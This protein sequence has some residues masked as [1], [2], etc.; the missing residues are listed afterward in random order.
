MLGSSKFSIFHLSNCRKY[1]GYDYLCFSSW[2]I[3]H[4]SDRKP[5]NWL[6]NFRVIRKKIFRIGSLYDISHPINFRSDFPDF[7]TR[8]RRTYRCLDDNFSFFISLL[9]QTDFPIPLFIG[10]RLMKTTTV[11][12][13]CIFDSFIVGINKYTNKA[14]NWAQIINLFLDFKT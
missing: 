10:H 4:S 8:L 5:L 14:K 7:S 11:L 3:H 1:R 12:W 13:C 9:F 2:S 6:D